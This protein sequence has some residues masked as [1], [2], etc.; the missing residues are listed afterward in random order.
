MK[1]IGIL[2]DTHGYWDDK[3]LFYFAD[4]DEV[5]HAGDIGAPIII[6]LLEKHCTVRAVCGNIDGG[7][8]NRRF[9]KVLRFKVEE[10]DVLMTH[11]GGYPGKYAP[12]IRKEIYSEKPNLFV[13]GHSHILK[14]MYDRTL[15]CLHVNPGAAGKQGWQQVRTLVK[16]T[17]DGKDIKDLEVIELS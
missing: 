16:L 10:C 8:L 5:W 17:I 12:T 14:V 3:Y 9:S 1:R 7:D 6:E 4:C 13:A 11:I 15:D 2:S